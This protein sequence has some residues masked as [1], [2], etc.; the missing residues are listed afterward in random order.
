MTSTKERVLLAALGLFA[1]DGYEAVSVSEIAGALGMTKSALYKHYENKRAILQAIIARMSQMDALRAERYEVPTGNMS[2]MAEAYRHTSLERMKEFSKAQFRYWTEETFP[3]C[4]R[5]MLTIS[6][7]TSPEM[8]RLFGQ[9]FTEGPLGY[10]E[11]LFFAM[12]GEKARS[13]ALAIGFY[14]PMFFLY[15]L[16]DGAD[17]KAAVAKMLCQHIDGF[18]LSSDQTSCAKA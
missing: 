5:K 14:A 13:K 3:A 18:C 7:H 9:Y 2:E 4:F 11:D 15:S 8:A 10:T 16:Y 17:H 1:K 12:T 6:Q